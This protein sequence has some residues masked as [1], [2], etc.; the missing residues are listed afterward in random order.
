[1]IGVSLGATGGSEWVALLCAIVFHQMFEGLGLGTRI[2][3]LVW[4]THDALRKVV[5]GVAFALIT[6]IGVAIGIG[7]HK[8]YNPNSVVCC[9]WR[10]ID[11]FTDES[12]S[13]SLR[14]LPSESWML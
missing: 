14:W 11:S 7:V 9:L 2:A 10:G 12:Q 3:E 1:M 5:M 13:Y 4:P 8:S 6:P